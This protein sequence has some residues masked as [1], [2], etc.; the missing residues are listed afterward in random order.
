MHS[1]KTQ[2][3]VKYGQTQTNPLKMQLKKCNP[4]AVTQF[5]PKLG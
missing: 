3:W 1:K 2:L 4:M 5:D